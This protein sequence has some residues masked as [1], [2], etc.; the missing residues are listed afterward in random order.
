MRFFT[1][2]TSTSTTTSLLRTSDHT[3]RPS[4]EATRKP[5]VMSDHRSATSPTC[6][7]WSPGFCSVTFGSVCAMA[8]ICIDRALG[9]GCLS[10]RYVADQRHGSGRLAPTM[11]FPRSRPQLD[12]SGNT[13]WVKQGHEVKAIEDS[14]KLQETKLNDSPII[15]TY[16]YTTESE[17]YP[18]ATV[19][20]IQIH[21]VV[22]ITCH[23]SS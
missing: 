16:I 15:A 11:L 1:P 23:E 13:N 10:N 6:C 8:H 17:N 21:A 3:V 4:L 20:A 14:Q 5:R 19:T 12:I 9:A 18:A 7:K 2:S 22:R